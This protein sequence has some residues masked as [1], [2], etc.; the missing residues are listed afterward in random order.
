MLDN[1]L[2]DKAMA[3]AEQAARKLLPAKHVPLSAADV[4][5]ARAYIADYWV[6]LE[7]YHPADDESLLGMPNP[8]LVPSYDETA[9][10]DYNELY[11]WDSYFTAI[12]MNPVEYKAEVE[13]MLENLIYLRQRFGIIPNASRMYFTSR[14]QPPVLTSYI[15]YVYETY[16]KGTDWLKEKM[17]QAQ[18][19]YEDVWMKTKHPSWHRTEGGLNRYYDINAL[20]DFAELESGWDMTTRFGR[21]CLDF[22]PVDLNSL[23]YKYEI[24]IAKTARLCGDLPKEK[25]W[26]AKAEDRKNKMNEYL[27]SKSKKFYFDYNFNKQ[28]RGGVRS[29]AGFYTM[30]AG[31]ASKEQAKQMVDSLDKFEHSGGL[32]TTSKPLIDMSIFGS[33][34][35][36]WAYPNG[37]APLHYIVITGLENY[38]YHKQARRIATKWLKTNTDWFDNHHVF[39][40]KYNMVKPK[41]HP[42][43]GVY[44]GQTGFGWTNSV[45]E[46]LCQKYV[47]KQ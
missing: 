18:L 36:Q 2:F 44:P 6:K 20:H 47:D 4:A 30:W 45:Y 11:Y 32:S 13:G 38:G 33:I 14:S 27:W 7:R 25:L 46:V 29:L 43:E 21:K 19:E 40:E 1:E 15:L 12:G 8:Y 10:F 37:W 34:K 23:L 24:D 5:N 28:E 31:L 35:T 9:S 17:Y 42:V 22:W 16:N 39:L 26:L 3:A 41:K